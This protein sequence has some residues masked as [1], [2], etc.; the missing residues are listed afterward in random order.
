MIREQIKRDPDGRQ[1]GTRGEVCWWNGVITF[2]D[3]WHRQNS[4]RSSFDYC[5]A[6]RNNSKGFYRQPFGLDDSSY[7]A[8]L[9]NES[10]SYK[11]PNPFTIPK[12]K[13]PSSIFMK[14][15]EDHRI[16]VT[17]S[18]VTPGSKGG[19]QIKEKKR[20]TQMADS[21]AHEEKSAGGMAR[22]LS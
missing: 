11:L 3:S 22:L 20:E 2:L 7:P 6:E 1:C 14:Q 19:E 8:R 5:A 17:R 18:S 13:N 16:D 9:N 21:V 12:V 10:F 4:N 15:K